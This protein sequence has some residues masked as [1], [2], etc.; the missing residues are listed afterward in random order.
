MLVPFSHVLHFLLPYFF[1]NLT[2]TADSKSMEM[3]RVSS[4]ITASDI[5]ELVGSGQ[6]VQFQEHRLGCN[7][8]RKYHIQLCCLDCFVSI[9]IKRFF[10][11]V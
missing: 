1:R 6:R 5:F 2:F 9:V 7:I 3:S 11:V 10:F 8:M 4:S